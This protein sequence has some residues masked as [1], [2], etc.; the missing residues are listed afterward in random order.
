MELKD[1]VGEL[2]SH[3]HLIDDGDDSQQAE[4]SAPKA[5]GVTGGFG[6][7]AAANPIRGSVSV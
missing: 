2:L 6:R 7:I 1:V 5:T 3:H 4:H